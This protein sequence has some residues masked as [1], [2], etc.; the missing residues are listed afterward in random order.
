MVLELQQIGVFGGCV[1]EGCVAL[2][3]AAGAVTAASAV[4]SGSIVVAGNV[5]YWFE[6]QGQCAKQARPTVP[7]LSSSGLERAADA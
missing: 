1:N 4:V 7:D 3:V 2:L 5:V 6:K